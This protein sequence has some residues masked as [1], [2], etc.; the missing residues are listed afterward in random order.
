MESHI[1]EEHCVE[2]C[3]KCQTTIEGDKMIEHQEHECINRRVECQYCEL[4]LPFVEY[5][6]HVERCMVRTE[7]CCKCGKYIMLKDLVQHEK[8]CV[9]GRNASSSDETE[10]TWP[11]YLRA[12]AVFAAGALVVLLWNKIR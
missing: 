6:N 10:E 2:V 9:V 11:F 5:M 7:L 4:D 8:G 1:A 12:A 3:D